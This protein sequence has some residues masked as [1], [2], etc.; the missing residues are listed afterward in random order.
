MRPSSPSG[1]PGAAAASSSSSSSALGLQ[2]RQR[3]RQ[4]HPGTAHLPCSMLCMASE[5][6]EAMMAPVKGAIK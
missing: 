2:H 1:C 3:Q 5:K 4:N 6:M